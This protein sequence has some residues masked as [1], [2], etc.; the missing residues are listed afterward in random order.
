MQHIDRVTK[1]LLCVLVFLLAFLSTRTFLGLTAASGSMR[2]YN[3]I[4]YLGGFVGSSDAAMVLLDTR[5]GDVWLYGLGEPTVLYLG[6]LTE[7][8]RPLTRSSYHA[9]AAPPS[10]PWPQQNTGTIQPALA[11]PA[12]SWVPVSQY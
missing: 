2:K 9:P 11:E 3:Y 10:R 5:N 4:Q 7:L 8:G 12:L 1:I 6:Q